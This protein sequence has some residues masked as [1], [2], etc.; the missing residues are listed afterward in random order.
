VRRFAL[1]RLGF[2]V[3]L[4]LALLPLRGWGMP[5]WAW[6]AAG[7]GASHAA[8]LEVAP[9]HPTT[10]TPAMVED[11]QAALHSL[12]TAAAGTPPGDASE[13]DAPAHSCTLCQVCHSALA[14]HSLAPLATAA[15]AVN[16]L[17]TWLM[18]ARPQAVP[19]A[20]FKPPR[21]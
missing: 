2:V 4:L 12:P 10:A 15:P 1:H 20:L 13:P 7:A 19:Q 21:G 5:G 11:A 8:T 9:C 16:S 14:L 6:M 17:P 18:L 3:W